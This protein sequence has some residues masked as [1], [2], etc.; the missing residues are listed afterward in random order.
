MHHQKSFCAV[1]II[2]WILTALTG[3]ATVNPPAAQPSAVVQSWETR[4]TALSHLQNWQ[5]N[6]KIAVTTAQDSGSANVD[7]SQHAENFTMSLYGP[8][9]AN[10]VTLNG[11]PGGVTMHASNGKKVSAQ[12]AEQLLAQEW[13]WKL[14][15]SHLKYW[16]R[17]LPVPNLPENSRFDS[18]HRLLTLNQQG[19]TIQYSDYMTAGNMELP[20]RLTI[21]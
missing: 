10:N 6:G 9:G 8:L 13:G 14:P 20:R 1:A 2:V 17:G 12:S 4:K 19:F 7:W 5:I 21:T 15:V 3:C 16:V 11:G 18:A